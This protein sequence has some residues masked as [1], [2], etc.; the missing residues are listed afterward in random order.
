MKKLFLLASLF[1]T[2]D[3]FAS[4][5]EN[6]AFNYATSLKLEANQEISSIACNHEE[7]TFN[8]L[9][10]NKV[11]SNFT[12][13][14]ETNALNNAILTFIATHELPTNEVSLGAV[15]CL[16][17]NNCEYFDSN[18]LLNADESFIRGSFTKKR[19]KR[20]AHV[21]YIRGG[22]TPYTFNIF[23]NLFKP[24]KNQNTTNTANSNNAP[25]STTP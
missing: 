18:N 19:S 1:C 2:S 14:S 8:L 7:C 24:K 3:S 11:K 5:T 6:I 15:V 17:D 23:Y 9:E 25:R 22:T 21:P 12:L 16:A 4:S 10:D 20:Q 13:F